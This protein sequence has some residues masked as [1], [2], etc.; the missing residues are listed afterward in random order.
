VA[1]TPTSGIGSVRTKPSFSGIATLA[2]ANTVSY[3]TAPRPPI[4]RS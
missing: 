3:H 4:D 2:N 1:S